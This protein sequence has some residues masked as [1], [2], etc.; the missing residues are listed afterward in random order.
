MRARIR[1]GGYEQ[2]YRTAWEDFSGQIR[3]QGYQSTWK[4]LVELGLATNLG[5]EIVGKHYAA[6]G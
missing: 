2:C 4:S 1:S 5:A 6:R 3:S